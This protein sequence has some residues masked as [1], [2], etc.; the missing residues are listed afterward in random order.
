MTQLI[1]HSAFQVVT[2]VLFLQFFILVLFSLRTIVILIILGISVVGFGLW[3][4]RRWTWSSFTGGLFSA[5]DSFGSRFGGLLRDISRNLP[6]QLEIVAAL[7]IG[8][9]S[10]AHSTS[11]SLPPSLLIVHYQ[12]S[13]HQLIPDHSG[14]Q[15]HFLLLLLLHLLVVGMILIFRVTFGLRDK[16]QGLALRQP[17]LHYVMSI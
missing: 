4:G 5:S 9:H 3:T 15:L 1:S 16:T 2:W 17:S 6:L 10:V 7:I 12:V 8:E 11:L 14:S 13:H